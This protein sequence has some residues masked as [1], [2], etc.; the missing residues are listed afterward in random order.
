MGA[1]S[2]PAHPDRPHQVVGAHR[3]QR[4]RQQLAEA[5]H[6]EAVQATRRSGSVN[7]SLGLGSTCICSLKYHHNV[8]VKAD[9][10]GLSSVAANRDIA[11][12]R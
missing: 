1:A 8:V 11:T 3:L 4:D 7:G 12:A 2:Q 9:P 6:Q 10:G 5:A